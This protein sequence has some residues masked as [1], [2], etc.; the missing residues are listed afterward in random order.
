VVGGWVGQIKII[1]HL[2]PAEV[3]TR[4]ELGNIETNLERNQWNFISFFKENERNC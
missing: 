1:N 3:E 4:A 2:S